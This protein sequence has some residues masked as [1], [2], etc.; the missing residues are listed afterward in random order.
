MSTSISSA[1]SS[2]AALQTNPFRQRANDM[3]ALGKALESG[4]LDAAKE[5]FASL[6]ANAPK[7]PPPGGGSGDGKI[8]ADFETLAKAL[9]DG[10]V[11]AAKTAFETLQK[12]LKAARAAHGHRHRPSGDQADATAA[13]S[14][15]ST[16]T[17]TS[18]TA[19]AGISITA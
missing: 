11:D 7:G 13:L 5:A 1:S 19:N 3:Q 6:Q 15:V 8:K 9:A 18:A 10:D 14:L 4:D 17:S 12:D 2:Q 16:T